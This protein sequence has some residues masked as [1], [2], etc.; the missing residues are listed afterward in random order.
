MCYIRIYCIYKSM[1]NISIHII[2]Y[3]IYKYNYIH[4]VIYIIICYIYQYTYYYMLYGNDIKKEF[5]KSWKR[6]LD[7]C[8][9]FWKCPW[10]DI[11]ELYNLLQNQHPKMKFTIKHNSKELPFLDILIKNINGQIITHIYH[12]PTDTQQYLHFKSHPPNCIKSIP[13]T[14]P[15]RIHTIITD[16]NLKKTRL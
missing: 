7:D 14:L 10:E 2:I 15:C 9:I 4:N 1:L 13:Y 11:N 3:H 5:T 12:K 6:Y 16:K 8:F